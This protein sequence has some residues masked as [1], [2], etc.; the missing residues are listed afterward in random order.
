MKTI[1]VN[2]IDN[3]VQELSEFMSK[4]EKYT[5]SQFE[6]AVIRSVYLGN[7]NINT[8]YGELKDAVKLNDFDLFIIG[9]TEEIPNIDIFK[10][11]NRGHT[12]ICDISNYDAAKNFIIMD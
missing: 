6:N 2:A 9:L 3:T 10:T 8:V 4:L 1:I 11:I 5:D 7:D 12:H